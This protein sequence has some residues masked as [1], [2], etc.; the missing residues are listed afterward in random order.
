MH[1]CKCLDPAPTGRLILRGCPL[2][3]H[4]PDAELALAWLVATCTMYTIALCATIVCDWRLYRVVCAWCILRCVYEFGVCPACFVCPCLPESVC[5]T[6]YIMDIVWQ[7]SPVCPGSCVM[8][9]VINNFELLIRSN[10]LS[11]EK[12]CRYRSIAAADGKELSR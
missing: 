3:S 12:D 11:R 2:A 1:N 9:N 4:H 10:N 8:I 7:S 5:W 6:V